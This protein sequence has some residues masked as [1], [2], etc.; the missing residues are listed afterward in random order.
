MSHFKTE[1]HQILCYHVFAQFRRIS[2]HCLA[3]LFYS[4]FFLS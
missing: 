3:R 1:T 4:R 2:C